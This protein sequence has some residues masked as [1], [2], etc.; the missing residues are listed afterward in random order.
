MCV[1]EHTGICCM[2]RIC[3]TGTYRNNLQVQHVCS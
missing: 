2:W 3:I 1:P